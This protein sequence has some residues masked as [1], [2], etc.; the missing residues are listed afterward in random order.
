MSFGKNI[1]MKTTE[2]S[3]TI[4]TQEV[5]MILNDMNWCGFNNWVASEKKVVTGKVCDEFQTPKLNE[6]LYSIVESKN[7]GSELY[8]GMPTGKLTGKTAE[9]RHQ[10]LD[11]LGF[12]LIL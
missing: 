2:V 11:P 8:L 4:L 9:K 6:V 12:K 5:T 7:E 3:Y 10:T 1:D